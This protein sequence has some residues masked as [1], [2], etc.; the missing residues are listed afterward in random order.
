MTQSSAGG[1]EPPAVWGTRA[2]AW[3]GRRPTCSP[4][5]PCQPGPLANVWWPSVDRRTAPVDDVGLITRENG[6][7]TIQAKKGMK[8]AEA[9]GSPL[10][11]ALH[12]LVDLMLPVFP[13]VHRTLRLSG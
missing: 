2:G 3:P 9:Q 6:W 13:T 1:S 8:L 5:L 11:E 10:A 4:R 12:Q 7:V